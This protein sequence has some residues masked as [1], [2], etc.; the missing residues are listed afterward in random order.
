MRGDFNNDGRR[1]VADVTMFNNWWY[2][3]TTTTLVGNTDLNLD[4][5]TN[6]LDSQLLINHIV[7][8]VPIP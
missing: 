2:G 8:G 6:V 1:N 4:G 7:N 3:H 5:A